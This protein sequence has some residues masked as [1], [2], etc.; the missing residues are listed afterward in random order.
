MFLVPK[1][2]SQTAELIQTIPD[3]V[4]KISQ[5]LGERFPDFK[6]RIAELK[7][8]IGEFGITKETTQA[9][10]KVVKNSLSTIWKAAGFAVSAAGAIAAFAVVPIYLFYML[11]AQKSNVGSGAIA[12]NLSFLNKDLRDDILFLVDQFAQ[13]M[14][15]FFRGQLLIAFLL[16]LILGTGLGLSGIKFGFLLGFFVGLIN[17]VPY[18]GTIIGLST[19]LPLAYL[20]SGGGI[21]L[22]AIAL[23]VFCIAQLIEAY[24]L[25][26][27]IMGDRTG[28][29]PMVIIFSVFFWGTALD[30]LLGMILAIPLTAFVVVLWE[31]VK[32]KYLTGFFEQK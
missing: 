29:H 19:I 23:A 7:S 27:K 28:L 6:D 9:A 16:G 21:W 25:T 2:I 31:L 20:Q 12:K 10:A 11:S 24:L 14:S 3:G 13:I 18:L 30:G 26:P 5:H 1:A 32:Q 8:S 15:S 4:E 17:I 22:A